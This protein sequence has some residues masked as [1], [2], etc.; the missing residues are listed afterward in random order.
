[1]KNTIL[2]TYM[3]YPSRKIRRIHALN[4]TQHPQRE[5]LYTETDNPGTTMEKYVQFETERAFKNGKVYKWETAKY[6]MTNWCLHDVDI[7]ILRFFE[8][9][10]PAIVYND[11]LKLESDFS[12][13]TEINPNGNLENETSLPECNYEIPSANNLQL[14]KGNDGVKIYAQRNNP[15]LANQDCIGDYELMIDDN[16]FEY[17]C[18][19]FLSKDEPFTKNK[20][21]GRLE[22]KRCKLL[23]SA[24]KRIARMEQEF[25]D[26]ARTKGYI[27]DQE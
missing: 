25:D 16:Y 5:D 22:E 23:G 13:K 26:W 11:A 1:M 2:T 10:F 24:H 17:M 8:T 15:I 12:S 7:D 3:P 21:E 18:D 9:K 19:Y 27:K 20:E 6:G 14:D 4:F